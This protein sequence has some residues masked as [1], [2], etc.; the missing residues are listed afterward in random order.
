[1]VDNKLEEEQIDRLQAALRELVTVSNTDGLLDYGRHA[2]ILNKLH[3]TNEHWAVQELDIWASILFKIGCADDKQTVINALGQRGVKEAF[4]VLATEMLSINL[5][6]VQSHPRKEPNFYSDADLLNLPVHILVFSKTQCSC[7][8]KYYVRPSLCP[9]DKLQS[10][11]LFF[12]KLD[13]QER[14]ILLMQRTYGGSMRPN[15]IKL[16]LMGFYLFA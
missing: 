14:R 11:C 12:S 9:D 15:F 2:Q 6:H 10:S 1:M 8:S 3:L 16:R 5:D 7:C 4:A 13:L